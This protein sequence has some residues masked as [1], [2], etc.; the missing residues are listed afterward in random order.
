MNKQ[1]LTYAFLSICLLWWI[2]SFLYQKEIFLA[3]NSWVDVFFRHS[4]NDVFENTLWV[5]AHQ[6]IRYEIILPKD[7]GKNISLDTSKLEDKVRIKWYQINGEDTSDRQFPGDKN[8]QITLITEAKESGV[9]K[10]EDV[11]IEII[12]EKEEVQEEVIENFSNIDV[13]FKKT[14]FDGGF[15]NL[16]PLSGSG[17]E[18]IAFIIIGE[19][20]F[21]PI[22]TA[23]AYY[24]SVEKNTFSSGEFFVLFQDKK[25]NITPLNQ[26][27]TFFNNNKAVSISGIVP[28][29]L[30]QNQ[31]QQVVLQGK[32][33][34]KLVSLQLS[35]SVILKNTSFQIISDGVVIVDIPENLPLWTYQFTLMTLDSIYQIP[36]QSFSII[37]K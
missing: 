36:E 19:K 28:N 13:F 4:E 32:G 31:K 14:S 35:N 12:P 8:T 29:I 6:E 2:G 30:P 27:F 3:S 10:K 16:I 25:K 37:N 23:D 18:N 21:L 15:N 5:E 11:K 26:K 22:K 33:F 17:L 9:F 20:S 24:L 7:Y 34:S 1:H